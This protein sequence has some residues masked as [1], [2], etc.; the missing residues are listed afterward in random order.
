MGYKLNNISTIGIIV[1]GIFFGGLIIN[2]IFADVYEGMDDKNNKHK[3]HKKRKHRKYNTKH[4]SC[5]N[6]PNS[7]GCSGSISITSNNLGPSTQY[8]GTDGMGTQ[9]LVTITGTTP[10]CVTFV[11]VQDNNSTD[12]AVL[13]LY[14]ENTNQSATPPPAPYA[15]QVENNSFTISF[16]VDSVDYSPGNT[17]NFSIISVPSLTDTNYT[18]GDPTGSF[19]ISL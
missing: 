14:V 1:L 2:Y 8:G 19:S 15:V 9:N 18:C 10:N 11:S 16:M 17:Y 13:P 12:Q 4:V 7:T 3:D 6:E 5:Y